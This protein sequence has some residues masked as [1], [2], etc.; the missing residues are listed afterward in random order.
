M[1]CLTAEIS[2]MIA[3]VSET[4]HKTVLDHRT[5][6]SARRRLDSIEL[7]P[8]RQVIKHAA[9]VR[10]LKCGHRRNL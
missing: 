9:F 5:S 8:D 3:G 2:T 6:L 7:L 4:I 10:V 1:S